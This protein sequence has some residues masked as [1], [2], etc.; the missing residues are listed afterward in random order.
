LERLLLSSSYAGTRDSSHR[1]G[2]E[3]LHH[4]E[5]KDTM[6]EEKVYQVPADIAAKAHINAEQYAEMYQR[7]LDDPQG[8]WA[9][10]AETFLTWSKKWDSVMDYSYN[11]EDLH[12]KWFEG[13]RLNVS[14][15][16]LD[17]H[18]ETRGDQVAIIWEADNPA[19][20]ARLRIGS[21]I[22][23]SASSPTCSSRAAFGR[24]TVSASISR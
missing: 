24:E 10:Q 17:R 4:T 21:C 16:C 23:R 5:E 14:Y 20:T 19:R 22:R 7:S 13:G 9:E 8:F 12:I 6:S 18:L 3:Q 1:A 15:N 2:R 11:A